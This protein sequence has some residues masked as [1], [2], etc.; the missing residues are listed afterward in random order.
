VHPLQHCETI[1]SLRAQ[2]AFEHRRGDNAV[3]VSVL[4]L[5]ASSVTP[6]L[7]VSSAIGSPIITWNHATL[8]SVSPEKLERP[9]QKQSQIHTLAAV[10]RAHEIPISMAL[11]LWH[12]DYGERR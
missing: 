12:I 1:R 11:R 3:I 9:T 7:V 5:S 10:K 6:S 4:T 8:A 2:L